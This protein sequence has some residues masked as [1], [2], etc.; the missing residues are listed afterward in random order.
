MGRIK[1]TL[2]KRVTK[3]LLKQHNDKFSADFTANKK[4]LSSLMPTTKSQKKIRNSVAGYISRIVKKQ[5][6]K[7]KKH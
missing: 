2:V 6:P 7:S 5:T 1:G 3:S 4:V